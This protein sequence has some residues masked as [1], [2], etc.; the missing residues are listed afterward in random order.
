MSIE[1]SGNGNDVVFDFVEY[2]VGI[3]FDYFIPYILISN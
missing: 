2:Y 1:N 3:L